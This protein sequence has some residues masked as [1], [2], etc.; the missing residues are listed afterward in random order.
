M[1]PFPWILEWIPEELRLWV[2]FYLWTVSTG[3]AKKVE[4][5]QC[6]NPSKSKK[7]QE[8]CGMSSALGAWKEKVFPAVVRVVK[9]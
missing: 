9:W 4:I 7:L 6:W 3:A 2:G 1:S 5:I 8:S